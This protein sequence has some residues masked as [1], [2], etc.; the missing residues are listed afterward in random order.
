M[1][2]ILHGEDTATSNQNLEL[3]LKERRNT[4]RLEG[5]S[6][7][8]ASIMLELE[9]QSLF[10]DE[11]TLV[12]QSPTKIKKKELNKILEIL[13][14]YSDSST[15]YIY[16][17]SATVL[18][19]TFLKKLPKAKV[20]LF[21]L[22]KYYFMLLDSLMPRNA[23]SSKKFLDS[24]LEK[25]TPEQVLYSLIKRVRLLLVAKEGSLTQVAEA[26]AMQSWQEGR[27]RQQASS[28]NY[29]DLSSL[30]RNLYSLEVNLKSGGLAMDLSKHI[31]ITIL[32]GVN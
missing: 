5:A 2:T 22:P 24:T 9:S 7:S 3:L 19:V 18:S 13:A 26:K 20:H 23:I 30:Y 11:K 21:E 6:L 12:I 32:L 4:T 17:Y 31:D 27:L 1:I 14:K 15:T 10:Q 29:K 16:V 28:W 25:Y 8:S